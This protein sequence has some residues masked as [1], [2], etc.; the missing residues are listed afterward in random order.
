MYY[1]RNFSYS[2]SLVFRLFPILCC[3][4][5]SNHSAIIVRL[6]P[7]DFLHFMNAADP[8]IPEAAS[9]L[10]KSTNYLT[11]CCGSLDLLLRGGLVPKGITEI[12]GPSSSGKTQ[13]CFQLCCSVQLP[14]FLGGL[15]GSACYITDVRSVHTERLQY[16]GAYVASKQEYDSVLYFIIT[17]CFLSIQLIGRCL[18]KLFSGM[19]PNSFGKNLLNYL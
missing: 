8:A 2:F 15:N 13:L 12:S 10:L 17:S 3:T 11:T 18:K 1:N 7:L 4:M 9:S 16:I 19:F 14:L 5:P 6:D